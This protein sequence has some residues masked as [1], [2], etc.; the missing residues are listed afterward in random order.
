MTFFEVKLK[1][2]I[3]EYE[4]SHG[5]ARLVVMEKLRAYVTKTDVL[6]VIDE[7]RTIT[8]PKRLNILIGVGMRGILWTAVIAHRARLEGV[9]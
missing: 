4:E 5:V 1:D 7:I 9:A 2:L 8:D 3:Y 6:T